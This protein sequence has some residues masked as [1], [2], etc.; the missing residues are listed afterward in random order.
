MRNHLLSVFSLLLFVVPVLGATPRFGDAENRGN[1]CERVARLA[2]KACQSDAR[3]DFLTTRAN[4]LYI[5]DAGE[6]EDC[7]S[8]A[9]E[10]WEE[11]IE[12]CEERLDARLDVCDLLE[13]D[14][15][16]PEIDPAAFLTPEEIAADPNPYFPLVPG[17]TWVYEDE[18][19]IITVIVTGDTVEIEGVECVVV[20]DLVVLKAG[21]ERIEDTDD[22]YSQDVDGNLW[23]FG[24][25]AQNFEDGR[26]A[27]LEGSWEAGVEFAKPGI[28]I[29][30]HPVPEQAYRQ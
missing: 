17:N 9:E 6:S 25:I 21:G 29:P 18:E 10:A 12:L 15:Y 28:L 8:E 22:Y 20:R 13:E 5:R 24:E 7:R 3:E 11:E 16:D 4:C 26:L 14:L 19:E 23:Y 30:R 27:D 2:R 1:A